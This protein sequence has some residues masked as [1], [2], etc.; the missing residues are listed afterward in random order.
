M[1]AGDYNQ[2]YDVAHEMATHWGLTNCIE[3]GT[4]THRAG[5]ALDQVFTNL[6]VVGTKITGPSEQI[7]DHAIITVEMAFN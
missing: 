3:R 7:T 4:V 5:G 2:L 1:L 6:T